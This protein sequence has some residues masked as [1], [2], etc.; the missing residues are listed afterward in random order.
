MSFRWRDLIGLLAEIATILFF[1]AIAV[2]VVTTAIESSQSSEPEKREETT[3]TSPSPDDTS[4]TESKAPEKPQKAAETE[5]PVLARALRWKS[6]QV[7]FARQELGLNPPTPLLASQIHQES[8]WH[9]EAKSPVG[10]KGL[11]QFMPSTTDH[12][13]ELDP[14]LKG[15]EPTSPRWSLRA[16]AVYID[17]LDDRIEQRGTATPVDH[18]AFILSAYN[19]GLGTLDR[20]REISDDDK[21][22]YDAVAKQR[23]RSEAAFHENRSYVDHVFNRQTAYQNL[24]WPGAT[25]TP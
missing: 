4:D 3:E 12:V 17:W 8:R 15:G 9:P 24:G 16:Q 2:G 11:A 22:W 13:S 6:T 21:R 7:R 18:W 1:L 19:G 23:S 14:Q 20:E 5:D 25:H 10:A